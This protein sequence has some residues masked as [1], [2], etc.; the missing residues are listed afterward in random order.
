MLSGLGS[1]GLTRFLGLTES[2]SMYGELPEISLTNGDKT[3]GYPVVIESSPTG[4]KTAV[5]RLPTTA[6]LMKHMASQ[7][8]LYRDLGRGKGKG[9]DVPT[10]KAD[11]ELF[12][13]IRIDGGADDWDDDEVNHAISTVTRHR[14]ASCERVG[15]T[16]VVT[17]TTV[18][19][20][21]KHTVRIPW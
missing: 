7:R 4:P 13:A 12:N 8:S 1:F 2:M 15:Q 20:E 6:E 5:L 18:F 10:P 21:L 9:E 14:V 16:F 11:R 17:L 3:N 19:G